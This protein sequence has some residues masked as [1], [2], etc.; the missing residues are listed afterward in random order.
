MGFF[1]KRSSVIDWSETYKP[2]KPLARE[3]DLDLGKLNNF[4]SPQTAQPIQQNQEQGNSGM[5]F[6]GGFFGGDSV[7]QQTTNST[8]SNYSALDSEDSMTPEE[9]RK[10]L[11]KRM[12][13]MTEKIEDLSNQI[14]H[15]QNRIEVL[16]KKTGAKEFEY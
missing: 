8:Q 15:L 14:Y 16:E 9:R 13:D 7:S 4:N 1:K 10:K 5:G 11:A 3:E 2:D 12:I 6:F